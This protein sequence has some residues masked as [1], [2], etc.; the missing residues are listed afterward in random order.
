[1]STL[2]KLKYKS[3]FCGN[4]MS[5]ILMSAMFLL[6]F[7]FLFF[8]IPSKAF[9][10]TINKPLY[11]LSWETGLVGWWTMDGPDTI[12]NITDRST[13]GNNGSLSGQSATTTAPGKIGQALLFDGSD[14]FVNMGTSA[15][16][17]TSN[18]TVSFWARSNVAPA[19]PDGLMGKTN[20]DTWSQGWGFFFQSAT[21]VRFFI[22]GYNTNFA[23]KTSI[24][25][26]NWT[27]Y[28]GT[29]DG[30]TVQV[31]VNGV[32]GTSDAYAGAITTTNPFEIGR[33]GT[34]T[35]NHNGQIDDVRFYSRALSASEVLALYNLSSK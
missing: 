28:V 6:L 31:Y 4:Q 32:A 33:L 16:Y 27:H 23:K 30:A 18:M 35:Y 11:I 2:Y 10:S 13:T 5:T 8:L 26:T 7:L 25:P 9:A 22:E 17:A 21:E 1:M 3:K 20:L 34:N 15:T 12:S 29:W 19:N 24:A 14:D